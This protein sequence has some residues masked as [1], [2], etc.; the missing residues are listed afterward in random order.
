MLEDKTTE[1]RQ[2]EPAA[3]PRHTGFRAKLRSLWAQL[4][5]V[6]LL[7]RH[8]RYRRRR[9]RLD[10][11][12]RKLRSSKL[13]L[14]IGA[15]LYAL[16]FGAEYAAVRVG[17]AV[18]YAALWVAGGIRRFA[19]ALAETA[20]PGA[21]QVVKDLFGPIVLFAKGIVS[22]L[23]HA[24][25]I[26]REQGFGAAFEASVHYFK[27]GV[28]RNLSLLPRMAMYALPICALALGAAVFQ[29]V[30]HQPYALAVRV[31]GETVGY[32]ANEDVFNT[33]REDVM[34]R[35][36]YAGSDKTELTIEP[37]Y[38]IAVAHHMLDENEMADAIIQSAGDQIGEGTAL[39]LDGELTAVCS[40]GDALRAYFTSRLE[41]Y[42]V[43]DD[44]N[45]SVGFNKQVTLED[46]LYFKDSLQDY[47][48][49]EKALSG[50]KQAQKV[51]TV[52][53]GD[54]LWDIAHKND[55]TF[56]ELCALNTNFKG[57]PL[58]EKSNI[59]EGDELI[60]TKEEAAL[61]VRITRIE[62]R[63]E[64]VAFAIETTKSNEYTKGTTKVL[65]EGQN[66]L[67]RVTFQN[68]Y[69]TNNVLVEQT[70]LSTEVIKEPV[71]KKVVQGTKK[72]KSSTKFITGSG[73]FIWPVPNYRYC[74]RWYGGRHRGVDICAPAGTPIYASAGGTVTK[75]GY[76][77]A[78]A[79]TGYGY[80]II[81]NHGGGYSSVYAHCL[82]LTVSAGQTVKQGQLI[83]YV[84]STGRSTGN[85]CHFEIRLNGS[86]IPPQNVFPGRK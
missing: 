34:E 61:E 19:K 68:V 5:C 29:Y 13:V 24:H 75:A 17:R 15:A 6:H 84:G 67:R 53:T 26:R 23:I 41:P 80:S 11:A 48:D 57:E 73:Q 62:T 31:N 77:K 10:N 47:A 25:R 60:V 2:D 8:R 33:A 59:R 28:R 54:T 12:A 71:N 50:V 69:D 4:Q 82:S 9:H 27:N 20:F 78:G 76:N 56:R 46:G 38:T 43:P 22:L 36:S 21:A 66:G 37:S 3:A 51:Y 45:V 74:S 63:E 1:T 35:I 30:I 16:G 65:Q 7:R 55:L 42:E 49:V 70:I 79:G 32:V 72:V 64:E 18:K 14:R 81:I 44:P 86:Y 58:N 39:Y 52:K 85:H 40:D 83:G